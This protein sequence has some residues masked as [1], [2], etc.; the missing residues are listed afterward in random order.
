LV[1]REKITLGGLIQQAKDLPT[2]F[3]RIDIFDG[4]IVQK[5]GIPIE[6]L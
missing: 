3:G 2:P 5:L 6:Y 4:K 1:Q